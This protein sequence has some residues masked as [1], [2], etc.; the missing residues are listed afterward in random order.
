MSGAVEVDEFVERIDIVQRHPVDAGHVDV[1]PQFRIP[2][3]TFREVAGQIDQLL[4]RFDDPGSRLRPLATGIMGVLGFVGPAAAG[5]GEEV[6]HARLQGGLLREQH[7][8]AEQLV[9]TAQDDVERRAGRHLG[10]IPGG[11]EPGRQDAV[12][13]RAVGQ[14]EL[15]LVR[16]LLTA[17]AFVEKGRIGGD[18]DRS[19]FRDSIGHL[20]GELQDTGLFEGTGMFCGPRGVEGKGEIVVDILERRL[21]TEVS[22]A[23]VALLG[24][25]APIRLEGVLAGIEDGEG[26]ALD[27]PADKLGFLG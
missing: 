9:V 7:I 1:G 24:L 27:G 22:Q 13:G 19:R 11:I 4:R 20:D 3:R 25:E 14:V 23:V 21:I 26:L 2:D 10:R 12:F 18:G 5:E 6:H 17:V 8:P 16:L 15:E